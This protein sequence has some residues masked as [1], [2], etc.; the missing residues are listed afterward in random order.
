MGLT[1]EMVVME[2][3]A[4]RDFASLRRDGIIAPNLKAG[5][6]TITASHNKNCS[7]LVSYD[8]SEFCAF[9][10]GVNNFRYISRVNRMRLMGDR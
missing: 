10:H 6:V 8:Q 4:E 3:K 9:I 2:R 5:T 1:R 7:H